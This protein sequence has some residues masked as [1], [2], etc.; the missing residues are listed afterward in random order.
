MEAPNEFNGFKLSV[1]LVDKPQDSTSWGPLAAG[2]FQII[3]T[4]VNTKIDEKCPN[5]IVHA[6]HVF[7]SQVEVLWRAPEAGTGCVRFK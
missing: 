5:T 6:S 2:V 1:E 7:V 3:P 4:E